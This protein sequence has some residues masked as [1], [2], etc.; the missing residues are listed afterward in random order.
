MLQQAAADKGTALCC[1]L[2]LS[3]P[4]QHIT[5]VQQSCLRAVPLARPACLLKRISRQRFKQSKML[6]EAVS[7]NTC[8]CLQ[9]PKTRW[10][11][12]PACQQRMQEQQLED[13]Y[14]LQSWFIRRINRFLAA[15]GKQ[16]IG[17]DEILEGG[18][19]QGACVMSWRVGAATPHLHG[20]PDVP[21][22]TACQ[23]PLQGC[24]SWP[25]RQAPDQLTSVL[26]GGLRQRFC[27]ICC[28]GRHALP[29]RRVLPATCLGSCMPLRRH[30]FCCK[31]VVYRTQDRT[32]GSRHDVA[33]GV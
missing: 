25:G 22:Y 14:E 4:L 33:T 29:L 18:L 24:A 6:P 21:L 20:P 28:T 3:R 32:S 23:T 13:E 17:W 12:C 1:C 31:Q 7:C 30:Q 9:C 8:A 19:A 11:S 27:A 10:R 16:L 15:Q 2:P 26:K 5:V